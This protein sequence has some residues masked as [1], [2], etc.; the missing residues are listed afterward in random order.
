MKKNAWKNEEFGACGLVGI[1]VVPLD[2]L[3]VIGILS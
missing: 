2:S 1:Q 3:G